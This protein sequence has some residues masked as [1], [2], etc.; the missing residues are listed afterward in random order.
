M[1]RHLK[2]EKHLENISQNRVIIPKKN[3]IKRN[4]KVPDFDIKDKKLYYFTDKIKKE[5]IKSQLKGTM[6]K[7]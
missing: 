1:S 4:V 7:M 2:N 6:T 3:P 5:P